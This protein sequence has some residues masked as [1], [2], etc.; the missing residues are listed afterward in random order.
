MT[1]GHS[2]FPLK[3]ENTTFKSGGDSSVV[4][5]FTNDGVWYIVLGKR[6]T[7]YPSKFSQQIIKVFVSDLIPTMQQFLIIFTSKQSH[8]KYI[9]NIRGRLD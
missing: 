8:L 6:S 4:V 1:T 2:P 3:P 9:V 7:I 5:N